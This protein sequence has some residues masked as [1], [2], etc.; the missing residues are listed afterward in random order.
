[1]TASARDV[2]IFSL[3]HQGDGETAEGL[4]IPYTVPGDRVRAEFDGVRGKLV[5]VLAPGPAR[6]APPCKHFG[7]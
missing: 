4:Y 1:M 2:E 7:V 5:E 6:V 3:G